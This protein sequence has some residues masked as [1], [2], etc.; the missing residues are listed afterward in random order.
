MSTNITLRNVAEAYGRLNVYCKI[1]YSDVEDIKTQL[2]DELNYQPSAEKDHIEKT[3]YRL[4]EIKQ[5]AEMI[6][7]ELTSLDLCNE[8]QIAQAPEQFPTDNKSSPHLEY[9]QLSEIMGHE[10]GMG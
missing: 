6:L 1:L 7:D 2:P 8:N 4:T 9:Y 5:V 10:K 3:R